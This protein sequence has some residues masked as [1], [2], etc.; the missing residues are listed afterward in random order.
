ME[1][2][3]NKIILISEVKGLYPEEFPQLQKEGLRTK[4]KLLL[5]SV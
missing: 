4:L 2:L 5:F 3:T 1:K